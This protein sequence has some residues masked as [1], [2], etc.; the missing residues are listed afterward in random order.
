LS[1]LVAVRG[2]AAASLSGFAVGYVGRDGRE[3]RERLA[4]AAGVA[5][6]RGPGMRRISV[7]ALAILLTVSLV[8]AAG[9]DRDRSRSTGAGIGPATA[10]PA[11]SPSADDPEGGACPAVLGEVGEVTDLPWTMQDGFPQATADETDRPGARSCNFSVAA[12]GT[13]PA[14]VMAV[15]FYRID[16]SVHT[17]EDVLEMA[18]E[19]AECTE[20]LASPPAGVVLA[21]QCLQTVSK[22]FNALTVLSVP[23]GYVHVWV[24]TNTATGTPALLARAREISRRTA[25]VALGLL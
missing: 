14:A 2:S 25:E 9:C 18:V 20:R 24:G 23:R 1:G 13:Y 7:A 10:R 12:T 15:T 22:V 21:V 3:R 11:P 6:E 16:R 17:S 5:F 19:D 8:G 4:A